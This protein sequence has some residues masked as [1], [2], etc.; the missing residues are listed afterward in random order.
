M[1]FVFIVCLFKGYQII[2][3]PSLRPFTFTLNNTF[4]KKQNK[5]WD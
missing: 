5:V 1:Q 3:K 2:V 4:L